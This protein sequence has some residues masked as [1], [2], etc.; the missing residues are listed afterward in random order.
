MLPF[1]YH[2]KYS[3]QTY[4]ITYFRITEIQLADLHN[5]KLSKTEILRE[6]VPL[7][8]SDMGKKTVSVLVHSF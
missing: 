2:E 1:L 3:F 6:T 4:R 5:Y 7:Q 8:T